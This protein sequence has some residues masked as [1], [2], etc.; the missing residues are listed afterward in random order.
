MAKPNEE[1]IE[2]T[3]MIR[4]SKEQTEEIAVDASKTATTSTKILPAQETDNDQSHELVDSM[5]H[6]RTPSSSTPITN[7]GM[8]F[9]F[10]RPQ[11][12]IQY[13]CH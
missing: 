2:M 10:A 9:S 7:E 6:E 1:T 11:I 3:P 5:S 4:E 12:T 13:I 8:I